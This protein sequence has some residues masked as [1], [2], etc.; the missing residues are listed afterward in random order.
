MENAAFFRGELSKKH[1]DSFLIEK[2][3]QS[4]LAVFVVFGCGKF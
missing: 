3:T 1:T 4:N 2:I